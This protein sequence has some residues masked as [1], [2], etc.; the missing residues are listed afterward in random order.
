MS[1]EIFRKAALKRLASPEQLDLTVKITSPVG[2][3]ALLSVGLLLFMGL[4]WG[5]YGSIPTKVSGKGILIKSG[6]VYSIGAPTT[7]KITGIYANVDSI[8]EKGQIIARIAQPDILN[9][10]NESKAKLN[11]L[12]KEFK[13]VSSG[14]EEDIKLQLEYIE[15]KKV[16]LISL[17][18]LGTE[19]IKWLKEKLKN[20]RELF[21]L[22]LITKDKV[23]N[24]QQ[25]LFDT[26]I[27]IEKYKNQIRDL[28]VKKVNLKNKYGEK[29]IKYQNQIAQIRRN[30][31]ELEDK[32]E[33]NSRVISP[34]SGRVLEVAVEEDK[35]VT[36]GTKILTMEL[37]GKDV[38]N[39]EGVIY[40]SPVDGKKIKP[41]MKVEISPANVKQ[42][43]YGFML[44]IVTRVSQFPSTPQGM[45]RILQNENLVKTL[46]GGGAPIEINATLVPSSKTFSGYRW[47]SKDG[48]P[49]KIRSGTLCFS[50]IVVKEQPPV[51]LVIPLLKKYLLGVGVNK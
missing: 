37:I 7:G 1:K 4:I 41:G 10:L 15:N 35:F 12:Q 28:K 5:I 11:D 18:K 9:K 3:L 6:G 40:V 22:G 23:V 31:E 36:R 8:I 20:N 47:S 2:W 50:S 24:V 17:I 48:P 33:E 49:I 25:Q 14:S 45:M 30:I 38:R 29:S 27:K 44:G 26:K 32:L 46:S 43:E 21:K 34:F 39:L 42:E 51:T 16:N 19:R 13:K